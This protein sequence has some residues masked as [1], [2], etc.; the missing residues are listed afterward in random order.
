MLDDVGK[1][2]QFKIVQRFVLNASGELLL[3]IYHQNDISL[4]GHHPFQQADL[5]CQYR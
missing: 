3:Q 1:A 4:N 2:R 5:I